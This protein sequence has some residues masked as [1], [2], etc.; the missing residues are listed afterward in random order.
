ML[1][2]LGAAPAYARDPITP[3]S[4]I[5]RGVQCTALTV[6]HGTDISSFDVEVIEVVDSVEGS[7][8]RILVRVSG[9]A[10]D[11]TGIAEGMSGSPV[12]CPDAHGV[13]GNAGAISATVG[14]YGDAVGLVT[15]IEQML[16]LPVKPPSGV[17][18][19]PRLLRHARPL[20]SP[21]TISGLVPSLAR[22][23]ERSAA[24]RGHTV[25]A[26]PAGPLA[27]FAPQPLVP[28]AAFAVAL[29]TGDI[30]AGAIG[31]VTYRDGATLYGFGHPFEQTG[32][33]ALVLQDAYVFDVI[34]NPL[35]D[36]F[37]SSYKLAAPGHTLGTISDDGSAAVVGTVG[38]PPR[39]VPMTVRV[40]D[41]DRDR[42]THLAVNLADEVDVGMPD[43][44]GLVPSLASLALAQGVVLAFDGAPA[45]ESGRLCLRAELRESKRPLRFCNRYV[46]SGIVGEDVPG[47]ALA[48]PMSDDVSGA[49]GAI[50]NARFK[51]LHLTKLSADATVERG[52]RLATLHSLEGPRVVR[53]GHTLRL[54]LRVR[55]Y[56]G[57]LRTIHITT[58]VPR[59]APSGM[60]TLK[61]SGTPL[62]GEFGG[63]SGDGDLGALLDLFG[64]GGGGSSGAQTLA[65][66]RQRFED[67][68]RYDGVSARIGKARW[69]AY[70]DPQLRIDGSASVQLRVVGKHGAGQRQGRRRAA[71][72]DRS[73]AAAA[74]T[75]SR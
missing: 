5:H 64:G 49:L 54:A 21:L 15:P 59:Y 33:R 7:G 58:H 28:G 61:L 65:D 41:G 73:A 46:A 48:V 37:A 69:H 40:H 29:A 12:Y 1:A 60:R 13:V 16:G 14:Q 20:A 74:L 51:A 44:P 63:G 35:S 53:A 23:V 27:T 55:L 70:R 2:A 31:T 26:V 56:R 57:P 52:L 50:D 18:H 25:V 8:A 10:V 9:P 75:R 36:G 39:T 47:G 11:A 42:T 30:A 67:V 4:D 22:L 3:L 43:G 71:A 17:H 45:D 34:G 19:A 24:A 38:A 62:E 68:A 72:A 6:V 32:R 66:V